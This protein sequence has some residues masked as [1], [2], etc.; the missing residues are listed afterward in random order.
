MSHVTRMK[1]S[2]LSSFDRQLT[3]KDA[4]IATKNH[5]VL[6]FLT[7]TAII[8]LPSPP[9]IKAAYKYMH[10][11]AYVNTSCMYVNTYMYIYMHAYEMYV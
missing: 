11:Y 6:S 8:V 9:P 5:E 10:I 7:R 3:R 1:T 4:R 2:C